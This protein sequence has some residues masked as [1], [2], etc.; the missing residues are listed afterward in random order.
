MSTQTTTVQTSKPLESQAPK[1]GQLV[2]LGFVP[3]YTVFAYGKLGQLYEVGKGYVPA[4]F[5]KQVK[6]LE[7]IYAKHGLPLV[8]K[9]RDG[10]KEIL[11]LVDGQIDAGIKRSYS[12]IQNAAESPNVKQAGQKFS[13][14]R[15][16][17]S[18]R[19]QESISFAQDNGVKGYVQYAKDQASKFIES[20]LDLMQTVLVRSSNYAGRF[21]Q[22]SAGQLKKV[23]GVA[24]HQSQTVLDIASEKGQ[25][26]RDTLVKQPLYK[27]AYDSSNNLISQAQDTAVY[28]EASK[29]LYP[30]VAPIADPALE[31][32]QPYYDSTVNYFKPVSAAA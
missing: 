5:Q 24:Q 27:K 15:D 10:G 25:A 9:V 19:V 16:A 4:S 8:T 32:L 31:K 11:L 14:S 12:A 22:D 1:K 7:D 21:S 20:S 2:R 30:V 13:A 23:L 3:Q 6:S 17:V 29:R 28:K 18:K 26:A